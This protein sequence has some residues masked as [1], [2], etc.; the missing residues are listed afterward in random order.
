VLK[1]FH[2]VDP[3]LPKNG[4]KMLWKLAD[5][6]H[7]LKAESL[8]FANDDSWAVMVMENL[9]ESKNLFKMCTEKSLYNVHQKI[10]CARNICI[11]VAEFHALDIVHGD[12]S[13]GNILV[14]KQMGVKIIDFDTAIFEGKIKTAIGTFPFLS[15]KL[16][17]ANFK[18]IKA[19]KQDDL[20]A[21]AVNLYL[22]LGDA[23]D[24]VMDSLM[25]VT[26]PGL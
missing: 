3:Q 25:D 10:L 11:A 24:K 17:E 20:F 12:I 16:R 26:Q 23:K 19:S 13:I 5:S 9:I 2:P 1:I 4:F 6:K 14:D 8:I 21:L 7:S 22:L 18:Q 15:K